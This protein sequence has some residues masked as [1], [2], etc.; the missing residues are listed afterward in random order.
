MA[1]KLGVHFQKSG[2]KTLVRKT[3]CSEEDFKKY[4]D[5]S[6]NIGGKQYDLSPSSYIYK[7]P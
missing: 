6:F 1:E 7:S 4:P 3:R 5:L 2:T